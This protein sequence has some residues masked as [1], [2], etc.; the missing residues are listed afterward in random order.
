MTS[1][2]LL[3][4]LPLLVLSGSAAVTL[5]LLTLRRGHGTVFATTLAGLVLTIAAIP[6]A[7]S[8]PDSQVTPLVR[9]DGLALLVV[10]ALTGAAAVVACL[11][12]DYLE[13]RP[14]HPEEFY[15]LLQLATLGSAVLASSTHFASLFLGLET[16]SVSLYGLI[17][18]SRSASLC[19][20]A[21]ITS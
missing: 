21:G 5:V 9:M 17:A 16:L 8:A 7:A 10:L 6:R 4:I 18:Y 19:A 20:E 11:A 12:R 2:D 14:E 15:V 1:I 3:P 13:K